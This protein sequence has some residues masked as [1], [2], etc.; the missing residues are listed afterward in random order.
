[1]PSLAGVTRV[2][3]FL[4]RAAPVT[5]VF[6]TAAVCAV[7]AFN[8]KWTIVVGP[9]TAY[10]AVLGSAGAWYSRRWPPSSPR[11]SPVELLRPT[12][13]PPA[14]LPPLPLFVGRGEALEHALA[15]LR[16]ERRRT[17][18]RPRIVLVTGHPGIGKTAFAVRLAHAVAGECSGGSLFARISDD[19]VLPGSTGDEPLTYIDE[20]ISGLKFAR[21][22]DVVGRP[23][24]R[25]LTERKKVLFV[26]DDVRDESQLEPLLNVAPGC[27]VIATSRSN[28]ARIPWTLEERLGPLTET[29]A[30]DL[31]TV[32][33]G[34]DGVDRVAE[35]SGTADEVVRAAGKYPLAVRM[36]GIALANAPYSSL[37]SALERIYRLQPREVIEPSDGL[38]VSYALLADEERT[39][40]DVIGALEG[41]ILAPWMLA[42]LMD[43][44][45]AIYD[46]ESALRILDALVRVR[47]LERFSTDSAG[48]PLFRVHDLIM[49][50]AQRRAAR[51]GPDHVA[52]CRQSLDQTRS[53]RRH[54]GLE[55]SVVQGA[56]D[57]MGRGEF[58]KALRLA[59]E[60]VSL[61]RENRDPTI[62]ATGLITLAEIQAELGGTRQA[63]ELV[64]AAQGVN[65]GEPSAQALRCTGKIDRRLRR[66]D[67]AVD[68]L[69]QAV[70]VAITA[71]DDYETVHA[72]RE[73]AV[74]H[75]ESGRPTQGREALGRA[76]EI[77]R[78]HGDDG[79][80]LLPGL[81]WAFGRVY[82]RAGNFDEA[83]DALAEADRIA[84]QTGSRLWG[85]W[86]CYENGRTRL[87]RGAAAEASDDA[88]TAFRL[89][90][91]MRHEYGAAYCESLL[92]EVMLASGQESTDAARILDH[93][94]TTFQ[95]CGD[96]WI[97]AETAL[98]T[99]SV[100]V[101]QGLRREAARL[102]E[103]AAARF[104]DLGDHEH[105]AAVRSQHTT[106]FW[107][108]RRDSE[109]ALIGHRR[110]RSAEPPRGTGR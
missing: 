25:E 60:S 67:Q 54:G 51:L 73:L 22:T 20:F 8:I 47:F 90:M 102:L 53:S 32:M 99:A 96:P 58:D 101:D 26:V 104:E 106:K 86:I 38:D 27:I 75:A 36:A 83:L 89:F 2:F 41:R 35:R 80:G 23:T 93:A 37:S 15:V 63:E 65:G 50:Y 9:V 88:S 110:G 100:R 44:T 11:S 82:R 81:L 91:G 109:H 24:L 52:A 77:A 70:H 46:D 10:I 62:E 108:H 97:E 61:G 79:D 66:L 56:L 76:A 18:R 84:R 43:A 49:D 28:L 4:G 55:R 85:A 3:R 14:Q 6:L 71:R 57:A 74:V 103:L 29:E 31:L 48:V 68:V 34:A 64:H 30:V 59:R 39:A 33:L 16:T 21:G 105:A 1:M 95:G 72:L 13:S 87:E 107:T 5:L 42:A 98:I 40:I 94:L 69:Q 19:S 92:G 12:L 7:V 78:S 17:R 45:G